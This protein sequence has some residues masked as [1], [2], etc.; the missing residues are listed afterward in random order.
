MHGL[1]W[2]RE[3][4]SSPPG[5]KHGMGRRCR[6]SSCVDGLLWVL[7]RGTSQAPWPGK[8]AF[9]PLTSTGLAGLGGAATGG[10]EGR[11]SE[12]TLPI[13]SPARPIVSRR[14]PSV[15]PTLSWPVSVMAL[16]VAIGAFLP[17]QICADQKV[18]G[19]EGAQRERILMPDNHDGLQAMEQ[20]IEPSR[21]DEGCQYC[22]LAVDKADRSSVSICRSAECQSRLASSIGTAA[23]LRRLRRRVQPEQGIRE[24][25]G[26]RVRATTLRPFG[27]SPEP[28]QGERGAPVSAG[29]AAA[30]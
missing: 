24:H 2:H 3:R 20:S 22:T 23:L 25:H 27:A 16:V 29:G 1:T 15:D 10:N 7:V 4:A 28:L 12:P 8:G 6:R 11:L 30:A 14:S 26:S 18:S 5:S 17:P 9:W 21:R 13:S 19:E